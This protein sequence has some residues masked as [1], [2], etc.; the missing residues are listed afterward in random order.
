MHAYPVYYE[1]GARPLDP[2]LVPFVCALTRELTGRPVL[3]EEFG[4]PTVP[5]GAEAAE[6]PVVTQEQLAQHLDAVLPRLVDAGVLGALVWC[7][8]DYDPALWDRP[9]CREAP[10]ERFFGLFRA[11][12]S[13]KPHAEVLRAFAATRP[14]IRRAPSWHG[15]TID[16]ESHYEAPARRFRELY[17]KWGRRR[18]P[19]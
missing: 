7:F 18:Q 5:P 19:G 16:A 10:H 2:D 6:T 1:A 12:G 4:A 8:A 13:P 17:G 14:R 9:P 15:P 3:A 11:D